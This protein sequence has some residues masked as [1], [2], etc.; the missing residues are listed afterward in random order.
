MEKELRVSM[1]LLKPTDLVVRRGLKDECGVPTLLPDDYEKARLATE[2]GERILFARA[3]FWDGA[4][5]SFVP[6]NG[7]TT[8]WRSE[9]TIDIPGAK[10]E[11]LRA[12]F[13]A[14]CQLP[15]EV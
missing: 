9:P 7:L 12:L 10:R 15:W 1:L 5:T 8:S 13:E 4:G 6:V 2:R 14:V 3:E 11:A